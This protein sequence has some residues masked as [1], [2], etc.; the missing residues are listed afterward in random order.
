M[1]T[2]T[3]SFELLKGQIQSTLDFSVLCCQA[4]P[5]LKAYM[6][7]VENNSA[8]KLP[9]ADHFKGE[10][11]FEQLREFI[12]VYRKNLGKLLFINTFSYFEAYFKALISEVLEFHGKQ[13]EFVKLSLEKQRQHMSYSEQDTPRKS[14]NKLREYKKENKKMKYFKH[15][16]ELE[17]TDFRFP[18]ELF[19]TFGIM[20]LGNNYK[21]LKASQIPY[22]MK[23]CF[24][25]DLTEEEESIFYELRELRNEIAHGK[26]TEIDFIKANKSNA[27][28]RNL[29]IK[30]D[31][32]VVK[33]FM[34]IESHS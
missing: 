12:P 11:N 5:A 2:N 18:S 23:W 15:I 16:R 9:D 26:V 33:H 21:N 31:K 24:G 20:E 8:P 13:E 22:V 17:H 29:A 27:F 25:V 32:H 6:K 30:I 28:L 4:V 19:A 14:A 34:L 3:K 10:P 1:I 7:A